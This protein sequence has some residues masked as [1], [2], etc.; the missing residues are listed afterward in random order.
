MTANDAAVVT[1]RVAGMD[2]W[3]RS[4]EERIEKVENRL[5][6]IMMLLF[7]NLVGICVA[8]ILLWVKS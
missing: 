3:I 6:A 4:L 2:R 7:S 8:L 5:T 1:E